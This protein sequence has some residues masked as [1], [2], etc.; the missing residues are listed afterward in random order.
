MSMPTT[1][2]GA[3][4]IAFSTTIAFSSRAERPVH[5]QDQPGA[6]LRVLERGAVEAADRGEDDVVE[7]ALAAAVSLHRVEAELERRDPLRAVGAA[8]RR[9]HGALD[10]QRRRLDQL[11]PVVD[12]V[13]RVEVRH[14][15]RVADRDEPVELPVVLDGECDPLLVREAPEDVRRDR[16]AQVRVELGEALV[17]HGPSLRSRVK[18]E[19]IAL[20]TAQ[21][22]GTLRPGSGRRPGT[23]A[24]ASPGSHFC[25]D[26][27]RQ[28]DPRD[29]ANSRWSRRGTRD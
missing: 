6:H 19:Q 29:S 8:D 18:P 1:P 26:A 4:R 9:V 21:R 28:T 12:P 17:E 13:E 14:A 23:D 25:V 5:H 27:P 10:R 24:Q 22:R 3:Q 7:V 2:R 11:R 20:Q 15:A 16:A